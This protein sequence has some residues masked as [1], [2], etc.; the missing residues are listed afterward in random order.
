MPG[1]NLAFTA[2]GP[3]RS[4]AS[5]SSGPLMIPSVNRKPAA[6]STS[7]PGVRIVTATDVVGPPA[8]YSA[9]RISSGSS[10]ESSSDAG[11]DSDPVTR[12]TGTLATPVLW[13]VLVMCPPA[14]GPGT[15]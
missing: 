15:G 11:R 2:F 4:T 1:F 12:P 13:Q 9:T 8:A 6:S 10:T 14:M 3:V 5:R 7:S